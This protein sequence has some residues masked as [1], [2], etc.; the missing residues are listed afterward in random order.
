M[1][2]TID[3]LLKIKR[4]YHFTDRRNLPKIKELNG[5]MS[6]RKLKALKHEFFPGGNQW[7]LDQDV[8]TGMD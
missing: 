7:S 4:M 6:T 3:P 1:E 8:T 5:I 2:Q